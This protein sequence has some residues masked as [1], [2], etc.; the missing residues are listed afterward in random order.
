MIT[1][2]YRTVSFDAS[3]ILARLIPIDFK[4]QESTK[5]FQAKKAVP[6]HW[7]LPQMERKIE[8]EQQP[9][10]EELIAPEF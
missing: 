1:R 2:S 10:L 7:I 5:M 8:L 4:I 3:L 9:R 6:L